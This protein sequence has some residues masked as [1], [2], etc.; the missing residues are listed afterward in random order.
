MATGVSTQVAS[1]LEQAVPIEY[2]LGP[3]WGSN[4]VVFVS[5]SIVGV[6][7]FPI[8]GAGLAKGTV[9]PAEASP[10]ASPVGDLG[11]LAVGSDATTTGIAPIFAGPDAESP[12]VYLLPP[13]HVVHILA[14]PVTDEEGEWY[15]IFDPGTQIIGYIQANLLEEGD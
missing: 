4:G 10:V 15:P 8:E 3:V 11:T 5:H 2:Q 13:N 6:Y 14:E 9:A 1:D 12:V 7:F